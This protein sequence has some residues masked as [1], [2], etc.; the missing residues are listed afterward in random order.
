ME[1]D[2]LNS[3]D[4]ATSFRQLYASH[5]IRLSFADNY[6]MYLPVHTSSLYSTT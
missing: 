5:K 2:S 6:E 1:L 3:G 4:F